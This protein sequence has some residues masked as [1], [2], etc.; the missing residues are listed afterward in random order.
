VTVALIL[1]GAPGTG[2]SSVLEALM[3]RL[4]LR[5]VEYGAIESEQLSLGSPC[6][7]GAQWIPQL[8]VVLRLQRD[9]G[10]SRFLVVATV[11]SEEELREVVRAT[12]AEK[13]V[14]VCLSASP[15]IVAARIDDR[16]PDRWPGKARLI[17]HSRELAT[18]TT[19]LDGIDVIIE[20]EDRS[21]EDVAAQIE[22]EMANRGLIPTRASERDRQPRGE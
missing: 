18:A 10:R 6:L 1:I 7:A 20:T 21:P 16:E 4:E 22:A 2:K 17:A 8:D 13:S 15:E 5:G 11:E 3:T 19:K 9:A 12:A 14:V